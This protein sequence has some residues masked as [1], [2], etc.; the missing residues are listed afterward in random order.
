[1]KSRWAPSFG[2]LLL[3]AACATDPNADEVL[4]ETGL[5]VYTTPGAIDVHITNNGS[6][7]VFGLS[8]PAS[9]ERRVGDGWEA[10]SLGEPCATVA[11]AV[12]P[13]HTLSTPVV[14]AQAMPAGS[15]S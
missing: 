9:L 4:L 2:A 6:G 13:G 15:T 7:T 14:I 8:C 5:G 10:T 12:P 3:L 1:M 11:I